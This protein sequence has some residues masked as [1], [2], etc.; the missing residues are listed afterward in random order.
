MMTADEKQAQRR[1]AASKGGRAA[2][3]QGVAHEFKKGSELAREA[4]RRGGAIHA[5]KMKA[6][7]DARRM[8]GTIDAEFEDGASDAEAQS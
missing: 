7:R 8:A 2:H 1:A 6:I 4:G 3:A 5:A